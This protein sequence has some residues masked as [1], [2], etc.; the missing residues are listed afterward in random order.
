MVEQRT[1]KYK[2]LVLGLGN[3]IL[4]DDGV[5]CFVA[6]E[7]EGRLSNK[8]VKIVESSVGGL[9]LLD[10]LAGYDKAIIIDAIQTEEGKPGQIYCLGTEAFG[11]TK[12]VTSPHDVDFFTALELGKKLGLD[13]PRKIVIFAIEAVD[14]NTFSEECT[15]E[16]REAIPLCAKMVLQELNLE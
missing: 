5:G 14:V 1:E 12:H 16:V 7:L 13:L 8:G 15:P 9:G 10:L 11:T 3:S 6:R 4:T 2:T